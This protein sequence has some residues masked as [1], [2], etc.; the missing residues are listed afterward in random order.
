MGA[1]GCAVRPKMMTVKFLN[2]F[3]HLHPLFRSGL[4]P[5]QQPVHIG[6]VNIICGCFQGFL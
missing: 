5:V 6:I 4:Y 3:E 2:L 1:D